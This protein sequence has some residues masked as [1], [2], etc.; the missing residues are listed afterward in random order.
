MNCVFS[1][2]ILPVLQLNFPVNL[3]PRGAVVRE[4][5]GELFPG[6]LLRNCSCDRLCHPNHRLKENSLNDFQIES[7]VCEFCLQQ[8][9]HRVTQ[10]P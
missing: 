1:W 5:E 8:G 10:L 3:S 6:R 9:T 4:G 7:C 2:P